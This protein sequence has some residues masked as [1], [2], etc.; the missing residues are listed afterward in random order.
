MAKAQVG[1]V[2]LRALQ[3]DLQKMADPRAGALSE[4]LKEA[5]RRAALPVAD[6]ARAAVPHNTGRASGELTLEGDIRVSPTR[7]G[8]AIRVGRKKVNWAGWIEFGGT[9]HRP[10]DSTRPFTPGGT[11]LYPAAR[12]LRVTAARLYQTEI[13]AALDRY[14]WSNETTDGRSVHD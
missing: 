7:T 1:V 11:F 12:Q 14:R 4:A 8:A 10:H 6:A 5:G 2:G 3:R 13:A 9:R